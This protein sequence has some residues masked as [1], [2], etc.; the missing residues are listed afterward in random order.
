MYRL[1]FSAYCGMETLNLDP[2]HDEPEVR[3]AAVEHIKEQR[4]KGMVVTLL[5]SGKEWEIQAPEEQGRAMVGDDEGI[6]H[7]EHITYE[8]RECGTQHETKDEQAYCCSEQE[9]DD[10]WNAVAQQD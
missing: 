9:S 3:A 7:I 6:L 2:M 5:E 4:K 8:C 1:K 10:T